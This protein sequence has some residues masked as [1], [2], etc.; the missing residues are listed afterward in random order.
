MANYKTIHGTLVRD[1]TTNPDNPIE[2]QVWYNETD[3]V[4]K[5]QIPNFVSSWSTGADLNTSR[6][7][8]AGSGANSTAALCFGGN[9]GGDPGTAVTESYDGTSWTEVNDLNTARRQLRGAGTYTAGLA[10][11]G[12]TGTTLVVTETWN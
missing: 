9:V 2:G 6:S 10:Y 7:E 1:Y 8:T 12:A 5:Y 4:L 3:K 11:G